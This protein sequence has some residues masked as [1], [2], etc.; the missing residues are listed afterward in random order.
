MPQLLVFT[1]DRYYICL[2]LIIDCNVHRNVIRTR[3]RYSYHVLCCQICRGGNGY[4]TE[5]KVWI[6][7]YIYVY[8]HL[9]VCHTTGPK[10]FPKRTIHM[11]RS[12]ASSFKWEHPLLFLSLSSNFL[13]LLPCFP[14][15]F[16]PPFIFPLTLRWLMSYI[17]GAPILDVSRSHTTTQHSR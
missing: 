16:I 14:F 4:S 10:P 5:L 15:T 12:R 1:S 6:Y 2:F 3:V 7:M 9:V 13:R 11:V 8:I 17:Y